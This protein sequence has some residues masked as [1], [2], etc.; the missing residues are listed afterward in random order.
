MDR[1]IMGTIRNTTIAVALIFAGFGLA[2]CDIPFAGSPVIDS[3][4]AQV[5]YQQQAGDLLVTA[6][7]KYFDYNSGK[8]MKLVNDSISVDFSLSNVP[9]SETCGNMLAD[10]GFD[11]SV[12]VRMDH[13][14]GNSGVQTA[15]SP[16]YTVTWTYSGLTGMTLTVTVK[17]TL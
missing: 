16:N 10:L 15:E 17:H 13:T 1:K 8:P 14:N 4:A 3:G 9:D 11:P 12:N 7:N 5:V 6:M 2:G